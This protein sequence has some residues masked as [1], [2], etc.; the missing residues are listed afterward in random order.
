MKKDDGITIDDEVVEVRTVLYCTGRP[1]R[2]Y[3]Y[4]YVS[5]QHATK[6]GTQASRRK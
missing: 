2:I 3:I 4:I 6:K 5:E 1:W